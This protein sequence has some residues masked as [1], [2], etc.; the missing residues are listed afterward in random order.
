MADDASR[1][2]WIVATVTNLRDVVTERLRPA[3]LD[4]S[5]TYRVR[6]R[7][8]IG[9][10]RW[11]WNTPQWI[12]AARTDEGFVVSGALLEQVG[13]QL[14]PLWPMQAIVLDMQAL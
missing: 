12:A 2:V 8:E 5:R 11:G 7:E 9:E 10:S 14:P 13:L 3:G 6:L 1:A 4:A